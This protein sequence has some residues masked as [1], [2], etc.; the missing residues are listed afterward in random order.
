MA[1]KYFPAK[2]SRVSIYMESLSPFKKAGLCPTAYLAAAAAALSVFCLLPN[3]T[4][5]APFIRA[6]PRSRLPTVCK[7]GLCLG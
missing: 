4:V 3:V 2:D 1:R 7:D 6:L 5:L